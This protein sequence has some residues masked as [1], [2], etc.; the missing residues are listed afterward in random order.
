MWQHGFKG[1]RSGGQFVKKF[2][3]CCVFLECGGGDFVCTTG[4]RFKV[5]FAGGK[6]FLLFYKTIRVEGFLC[7]I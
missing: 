2:W 3:T 6:I 1:G 5:Q 7:T 4:I